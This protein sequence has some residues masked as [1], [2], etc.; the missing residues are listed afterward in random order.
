MST[1]AISGSSGLVGTALSNHLVSGGHRVVRLVRGQAR[2]GEVTY[3]AARGEIDLRALEEVDAIVHLAGESV[4]SGRWTDERKRRIEESRVASTALL[5]RTAAQLDKRPALVCASAIGLYGPDCGDRWLDESSPA[6]GGFL[7]GVCVAW[8]A[9]AEPAREAGVRT[10]HLRIGVVLASEGGALAKLLPVFRLGGGGKVGPGT[11]YMS[12]VAKDDV[13]RAFGYVL[14]RPEL[15][16]AF[17]VVAPQPVT[18]AEFTRALAGALSR[19]A[20]VPVPA[21]ALRVALGQMADETVLASQRV[22][23]KRLLEAGFTFSHPDI[24]SGIAAS[25]RAA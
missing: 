20:I 12:W 19:P 18:N 4:A 6:G 16:G 9:A 21:F 1:I 23:P 7:A 11:Q 25:L 8:E 17:N 13:T 2:P 15:S 22:R 14:D 5:A 10:A 24:T 3:D